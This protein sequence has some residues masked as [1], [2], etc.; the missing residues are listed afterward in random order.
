MTHSVHEF[1]GNRLRVR[2]CG[3]CTSEDALLLVDHRLP[4]ADHFW[5]PP[6]G[7]VE[8]GESMTQCLVREMREE[9]GL[10]VE[11]GEFLF[12]TEFI[13]PPLHAI[14]F[15]FKV[16]KSGGVLEIGKDPE[17]TDQII[18]EVKF[19]PWQKL[20]NQNPKTLHGIFQKVAEPSKIMDLR[21]YFKL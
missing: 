15:F 18:R 5:I 20:K 19:M 17:I 21:G 9:T 1:Y 11:P 8:F 7:G 12:V 16:E 4:G 14:E 10:I 13:A 2:A 3:L 6:G